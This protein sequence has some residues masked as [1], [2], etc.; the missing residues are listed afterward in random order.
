MSENIFDMQFLKYLKYFLFFQ[1]IIEGI[2][3]LIVTLDVIPIFST[4]HE[5]I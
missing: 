2:I 1:K 4:L 5:S 3:M